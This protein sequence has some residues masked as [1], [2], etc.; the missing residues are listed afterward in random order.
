M[1]FEQPPPITQ[2]SISCRQ[3]RI[4][5]RS[6]QESSG[7]FAGKAKSICD[8]CQYQV[9]VIVSGKATS[10]TAEA[11]AKSVAEAKLKKEGTNP[12][13]DCCWERI[14]GPIV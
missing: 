11:S 6:V 1:G 3:S 10:A 5:L 8:A 13:Y 4:E 14:R 12:G 7:T 2:P 9:D